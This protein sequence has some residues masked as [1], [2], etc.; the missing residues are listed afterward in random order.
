MVAYLVFAAI[1]GAAV[2]AVS[3]FVNLAQPVE[4][5]RKHWSEHVGLGA[6]G[7]VVV[8]CTV[9]NCLSIVQSIPG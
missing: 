2:F 7:C 4:S 3:G 9:L 8:S 1:I 6:L 5:S